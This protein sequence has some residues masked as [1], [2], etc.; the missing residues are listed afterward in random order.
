MLGALL[1]V[2]V[3]FSALTW[4]RTHDKIALQP[5]KSKA[6]EIHFHWPHA[7]IPFRLSFI[8][9][10]S[11]T[12]AS[13]LQPV[14]SDWQ[15]AGVNTYKQ[16]VAPNLVGECEVLPQ[17]IHFCSFNYP[18]SPYVAFSTYGA[19]H[20]N[21]IWFALS[22]FNDAKFS[23]SNT[24]FRN[25]LLCSQMG[26]VLGGDGRDENTSNSCME[27]SHENLEARQHPD[28]QDLT[29]LKK[30]YDHFDASSNSYMAEKA[31]AANRYIASS[32]WGTLIS[33]SADGLQQ[34]YR[35]DLGDGYTMVT[36][37]VRNSVFGDTIA[38]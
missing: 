10:S 3:S 16:D 21:H 37:V 34:V 7:T 28:S 30:H 11:R 6:D 4:L 27:Y 17:S 25:K 35:Q 9:S 24:L 20:E 13:A 19:N 8:N 15:Q 33:S 32:Q 29:A 23:S 12:W 5:V 18:S 2:A 36:N 38:K 22:A 1:I 14:L 26:F 31:S